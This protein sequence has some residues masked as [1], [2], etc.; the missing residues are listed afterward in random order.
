[1]EE[2]LHLKRSDRVPE[3]PET[4]SS[5]NFLSYKNGRGSVSGQSKSG[6]CEEKFS[7]GIFRQRGGN[8]I[9]YNTEEC[10][11]GQKGLGPRR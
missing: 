9:L 1:M 6:I 4:H 2:E 8:P 11:K 3:T 10:W 7:T 5:L